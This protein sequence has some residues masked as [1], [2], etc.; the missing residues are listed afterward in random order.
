MRIQNFES[1]TNHGNI[2]GRTDMAH[3]LEAGLSATDPYINMKNML[4]LEGDKLY[5]GNTDYELIDDPH[6][7]IDVF[8]LN[9]FD[10]V[11][12]IGAAKGVQRVALAFEDILGD[13]LTGGHVIGKHGDDIICKKIGVTLGAHPVPDEYCVIGCQKIL[14]LAEDITERDLVFT[15]TGN[16]VSSLLTLPKEGITLKEVQ[17]L[18]HMMQIEKGAD[19]IDL[20]AVRNHIDQLKGGLVTRRFLPAK[21]V[22]I[23]AVDLTGRHLPDWKLTYEEFLTTGNVFMHT[24]A[25]GTTLERAIEV[26][27]FSDAWD[28][29]PESI[30]K[31]LLDAE[32]AQEETVKFDEFESFGHR[33]YGIMPFTKTVLP[34]AMQKAEELGY[35]ALTLID[36]MRAEASQ[37]GL[38][39]SLIGMNIARLKEP[40][41]AP[42]ALFTSGEVVVTVGKET[43]VG[44]RNQEYCLSAAT[45]LKGSDKV[46]VGAVDTD[47]TDGPG[48]L[49]LDGAPNCL[50]GG[51]V[52][53]Y[54]MQEAQE[55]GVD[56]FD[57]LKTHATS[58]ALWRL[59]SGIHAEQNISVCDL[60]CVLIM[61]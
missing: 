33:V 24:V 7:G 27:K 20:N 51:I 48:G 39:N 26:L 12:V 44:G 61:E 4:R 59:D 40:L 32:A 55:R 34:A 58:Q 36:W 17:D 23:A 42:V 37:A 10:R 35:K 19:T 41:Q 6:T 46:V 50:A 22:H 9:D 57:A 53:G 21:M 43:G 38:V 45:N 14:E 56:V 1:L 2:K 60:G 30:R 31:C 3:I 29:T 8:D 52:D 18:T 16:G 5:V 13:R 25:D 49:K 28:R 11:Y 54:T 15:I 47:G